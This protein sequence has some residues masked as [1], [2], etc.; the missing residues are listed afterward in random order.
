MT[1]PVQ[2]SPG[3]IAQNAVSRF[4]IGPTVV[5]VSWGLAVVLD[6]MQSDLFL[7]LLSQ[8]GPSLFR[9]SLL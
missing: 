1:G 3:S 5:Q 4:L 9:R 7:S 8:D 6:E 2:A